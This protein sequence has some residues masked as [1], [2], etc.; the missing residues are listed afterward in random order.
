MGGA[1]LSKSLTQFSVDGRGCVSSLLFDLRPNYGGGGEDN[2]ASF[3]RSHDALLHSVPPPCSP[4]PPPTPPQ[5]PL[6]TPG[7]VWVSLLWGH[8]SSLLGPGAHKALFVPFK[9][10]FPQSG[11]S[12][13]GSMVGL[14]VTSS[15]RAYPIPRSAARRALPLQQSTADAYL[16][17]RHSHTVLAQ[18][19]SLWGL[20]EHSMQRWA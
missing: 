14:M 15:K 4:P 7:Q 12:S 3:R 10:L 8:C 13:A 19:L 16:L 9:S 5:R 11:V 1:V 6:G 20:R 2:A 18:S 17:S